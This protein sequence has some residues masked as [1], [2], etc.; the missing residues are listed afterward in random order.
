[1]GIII[2]AKPETVEKIVEL[3]PI[4]AIKTPAVI[5]SLITQTE[6]KAI[7]TIL[8]IVDM[9]P[10][11]SPILILVFP[12]FTSF[13]WKVENKDEFMFR[14]DSCLEKLFIVTIPLIVLIKLLSESAAE[15][16]ASF[17]CIIIFLLFLAISQKKNGEQRSVKT[18]IR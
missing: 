15:L 6:Q 18:A 14:K 4:T 12:R 1:M 5:V 10:T 2:D 9:I 8:T 13:S 3:M 17:C 7:K 11:S 16:M